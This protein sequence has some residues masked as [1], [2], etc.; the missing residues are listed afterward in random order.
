M[1]QSVLKFNTLHVQEEDGKYIKKEGNIDLFFASF[2]SYGQDVNRRF[3]SVVL[4]E[5]R[6]YWRLFFQMVV[7]WLRE[8]IHDLDELS[9]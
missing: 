1:P 9:G 3:G 4:R 5:I 8:R 7:Q 6:Y 2:G